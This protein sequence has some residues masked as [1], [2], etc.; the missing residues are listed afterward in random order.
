ML[1]I[2][3]LYSSLLISQ[4]QKPPQQFLNLKNQLE[5]Y[6][7]EVRVE[8]PPK[9]GAYGLLKTADKTIWIN[10]VV[11]DLQIATPTIVHESVHAAQLCAGNGKTRLLGLEIQPIRTAR[12]FFLRYTDSHKRNLEREAYA[13]QTQ[14]N[15]FEIA[16]NLLNKHCKK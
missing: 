9:R 14:P 1:Q 12:R 13:V 2:A 4:I 10:P 6:G 11:F 16:T 8:L 7:F 15:S 5:Q 3:V